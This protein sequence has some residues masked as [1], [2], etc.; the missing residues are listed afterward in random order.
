LFHGGDIG[1]VI[2]DGE[3]TLGRTSADDRPDA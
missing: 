1:D 2:P 3:V